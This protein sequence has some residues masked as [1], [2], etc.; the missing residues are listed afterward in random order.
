MLTEKKAKL[1]ISKGFSLKAQIDSLTEEYNKVRN[2]VYDY[3]DQ[4][5]MTSME[6]PALNDFGSTTGLL[7]ATKVDRVT[8]LVYD[9]PK[10]KKKL[11]P[12]L[13]NEIV[14]KTY[15]ITDINSLIS[16]LK[17][18]GIKPKEFKKLITVSEKVNNG[19]IQ[20]AYSVGE[21]SLQ[22]ISDAYEVKVSKSLQ[23]RK[24]G[25]KD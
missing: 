4:N 10:L 3:L 5:K 19:K 22:D 20:Q 1:L 18:A 7:K 17:K 24:T 23:I 15:T 9:I 14:D 12:E 21:I 16:L 11:D 13:F 2:A 25:E 8:S 6:A